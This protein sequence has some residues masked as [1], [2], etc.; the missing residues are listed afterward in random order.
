MLSFHV[1]LVQTDRQ[2]MIKQY[3][4]DISIQGHENK[5]CSMKRIFNASVSA[6]RE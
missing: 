4:P 2:T 1:K 5:L 3:A 6:T